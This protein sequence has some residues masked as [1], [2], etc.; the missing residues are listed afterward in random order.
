MKGKNTRHRSLAKIAMHTMVA[1]FSLASMFAGTYAW[2]ALSDTSTISGATIKIGD[3]STA[4][5]NISI[6]EFYGESEDG[7]TWGFNTSSNHSV[8]I[9]P[10]N[11]SGNESA[12]L[13]MGNYTLDDPHHPVLYLFETNGNSE[14][15]KLTTEFCYLAKT[16]PAS[17]VSV[18]TYSSLSSYADN[19]LI[20][21]EADETRGGASTVY[22]YVDNMYVMQWIDLQ[23]NSRNPLS[24][25]IQM[26][27]FVFDYN[28][29]TTNTV[30]GNLVVNGSPT[31]KTYIPF[32]KNT[33]LSTYTSNMSSFAT[34]R[35]GTPTF[36]N[37]AT[38]YSGETYENGYIGIVFDYYP[39]LIEDIY[40]Y[41]LG[42]TYLNNGLGFTCDWN[43]EI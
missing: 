1:I 9:D 37:E 26:H 25:I 19:T 27:S 36:S 22:K 32:V 34:I 11:Y 30:T 20:K 39:E 40:S 6:H 31:Q 41:F 21:V 33:C 23:N 16:E 14:L 13:E 43:M 8:T 28:P 4:V 38:V 18:P 10:E 5:V 12:T 17:T 29:A 7:A 35:N 3:V 42:N 15:I 2:F 24:S